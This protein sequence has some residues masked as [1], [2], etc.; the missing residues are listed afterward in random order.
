MASK[1]ALQAVLALDEVPPEQR[2]LRLEA[3]SLPPD[4]KSEAQRLLRVWSDAGDSFLEKPP[5]LME[6]ATPPGAAGPTLAPSHTAAADATTAPFPSSRTDQTPAP[7]SDSDG[8]SGYV[9][10][11]M[12][13]EGGMGVVWKARQLATNRVV[14]LKMISASYVGSERIRLRFGR[15]VELAANLEHP[16][17]ARI[18]DSGLARGVCFCAMELVDGVSLTEYARQHQLKPRQRVELMLRVC[19]G[20]RYA[21]EHGVIHRDLKP[22]N[23]LV[24]EDGTPKLLDFGV[25]KVVG[26][27]VAESPLTLSGDVVG[28]PAY[29]S[30][31][32]ARGDAA[33]ADT[34]GD[35]WGLGAILFELLTDALPF[36]T[37]DGYVNVL[38]RV[39]EE[40]PRRP[41]TLRADLDP[42]LEAILLKCLARDPAV[43]YATAGELAD[44]LKRYLDGEPLAARPPTTFYFLKKRV[45]RHK[46][47]YAAAAVATV[48]AL[49]GIVFYVISI[50]LE[51]DRTRAAN[52]ASERDLKLA[53]ERNQQA[54][55]QRS[56]ALET[57]HSFI[58]DA[59]QEL[60]RNLA[61]AKL[62]ESL[63]GIART[64]LERIAAASSESLAPDRQQAAA[65]VVM[66]DIAAAAGDLSRA[67]ELY[68]DAVGHYKQVR[69]APPREPIV[70][71]MRLARALLDLGQRDAA[72]EHYASAGRDLD[73]LLA[74]RS[75][76]TTLIRDRLALL[77]SQGDMA[78]DAGGHDDALQLYQQALELVGAAPFGS[79][80]RATAQRRIAAAWEVRHLA[81]G[82]LEDGRRAVREAEA[83]VTLD[84]ARVAADSQP[85]V[86]KEFG[87][88]LL[89]FARARMRSGAP[90]A[91]RPAAQEA[92]DILARH[93]VQRPDS[94]PAA[95]DAAEALLSLVGTYDTPPT[96]L[97]DAARQLLDN[98]N[99]RDAPQSPAIAR[100]LSALRA[101][102]G[103]LAGV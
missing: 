64:G 2:A 10:L 63:L 20:V 16:F 40:D 30:P 42:E 74:A 43:R 19:Q 28:T 93:A 70:A 22:S 44:E 32:Q 77:I 49:A 65:T 69:D 67:K 54:N 57:I 88:S 34:R 59:Q 29:M 9:K 4:V 87:L 84:R 97:T 103:R 41:R 5:A 45:A 96:G 95:L 37:G 89:R 35:V 99:G 27:G 51:R 75:G 71:R 7:S 60:H 73:A 100:R 39:A 6:E 98:L 82:D 76:D 47:R 31:E 72:A 90:T 94:L 102:L 68:A 78:M 1:A 58:T 52:I 91:A 81:S 3:M 17:I 12:L 8:L 83:A 25:A 92:Y 38:R 13:G 50:R 101:E 26:E 46:A 21:H 36:E 55:F 66:G 53:L 11:N 33:S 14:A 56:V 23:I 85:T 18:Y 86:R 24:C 79:D 48:V 15:E 62:R 61:D 80:D